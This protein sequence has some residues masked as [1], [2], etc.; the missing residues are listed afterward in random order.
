MSSNNNPDGEI[1]GFYHEKSIFV[2][3]GTG[4]L[5]KVLIRKLVD[6]CPTIS[7]IYLL[8]RHK[9]NKAPQDR[10]N[11]LFKS[12][13]FQDLHE[14]H[15]SKIKALSGDITE[16]ELGLSKEDLRTV[17]DEVSI[18]FHSA[19]TVR[20][21]EDLSKYVMNLP[22]VSLKTGPFEITNLLIR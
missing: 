13:I 22:C 3:G 16:P 18:I 14:D 7:K 5:G 1:K 19:A 12:P 20:F 10:L 8:I 4:F 6:S 9:R 11:D 21:D 15:L 17:I 2:T